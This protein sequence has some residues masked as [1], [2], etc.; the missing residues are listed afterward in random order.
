MPEVPAEDPIRVA[1]ATLLGD[2]EELSALAGGGVHHLRAPAGTEYAYAIFHKQSGQSRWSMRDA[3]KNDLWLVKGLCRGGDQGQAEAIDARCA[4]LLHNPNLDIEG[5][6]L[7][8]IQRE[9]DV[10]YPEDDS[11]ETIFHVGA[12][13]RLQTFERDQ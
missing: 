5:N 2:D 13:Y 4:Q 12:L 11:G 10:I 7:L 6:T 3:S 9:T 1:L 8:G